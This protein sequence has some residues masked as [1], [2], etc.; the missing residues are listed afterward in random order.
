MY[1]TSEGMGPPSW[2]AL[3][4]AVLAS[5]CRAALSDNKT[6]AAFQASGRAA[7]AFFQNALTYEPLIIHHA[8]D[9]T[10]VQ[11][12]AVLT[13]FAQ[14]LSNPQRLEYTLCSMAVRLAQGLVLHRRLGRLATEWS[15]TEGEQ[16]QRDRV[17]WVIYGLDKTIALRCG[18]PAVLQDDEIS[19]RFPRRVRVHTDDVDGLD[20]FLCFIRMTRIC[21]A[22]ARQ[23]YSVAALSTPSYQLKGTTDQLLADVAQWRE[24]IPTRLRPGR[25]IHAIASS[26]AARL[27]LLVLHATYFYVQCAIYRRF[28]PLFTPGEEANPETIKGIVEAARAL[29]LLTKHLDVES[30]TPAWLVFY[31]PMTALT[32]IF[33]H[34]V[35]TSSSAVTADTTASTRNDMGH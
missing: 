4:N 28:T 30:F 31:Y 25:P 5:G 7:W 19:C 14:G 13:V 11:A 10:A 21:G 1:G 15:L 23:L 32:T 12:M 27:Q 34:V 6:A 9:L 33:V 35:A 24:T 16:R 8:T 3:L 18:R 2:H 20:F 22:V 26:T 29:V 17:F